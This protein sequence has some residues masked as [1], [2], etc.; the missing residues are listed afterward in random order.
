[1]RPGPPRH[2]RLTRDPRHLPLGRDWHSS[3]LC[4]LFPHTGR[5]ASEMLCKEQCKSPSSARLPYFI[6]IHH[7]LRTALSSQDAVLSPAPGTSH[8]RS[9]PSKDA[10][11]M[12][13][14]LCYRGNRFSVRPQTLKNAH[15]RLLT[16]FS[17][18]CLEKVFG[19]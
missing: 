12:E 1:M 11:P 18:T 2:P 15:L 19:T 7:D 17:Q 3:H 6:L 4:S 5:L 13:T 10:A 8:G 14:S 9:I 16:N